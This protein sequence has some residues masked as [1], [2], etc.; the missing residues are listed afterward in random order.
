MT[1][2]A[3]SGPRRSLKLGALVARGREAEVWD[4]G[5]GAVL[6]LYLDPSS[7]RAAAQEASV[8]STL[9]S[10]GLSVPSVIEE[11]VVDGRPGL[12]LERVAG[13]DLLT[14]LGRRPWLVLRA[15]PVLAHAQVSV[16]DVPAPGQLPSMKARLRDRLAESGQ[17]HD[18]ERAQV[19]EMLTARPDGD[20][21]CHGD[22]HL[23]N[24]LVAAS[25]PSIIDWSNAAAG[26]PAADVARSLVIMQFGEVPPG[27]SALVRGLAPTLRR[28]VVRRYVST[29]RSMRPGHLQGLHEWTI[30]Q[31]AARLGET[32]ERESSIIRAWLE[33]HLPRVER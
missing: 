9:Q 6:K 11:T 22:L 19:L 15:G 33:R 13:P 17:L 8:L 16:N 3:P 14:A 29:Y 2:P 4:V 28:L 20:R 30:I 10:M 12:V 32:T 21:L 31:A 24:L 7:Q 26:P 23:E 1:S 5:D 18:A 25:L 27:A